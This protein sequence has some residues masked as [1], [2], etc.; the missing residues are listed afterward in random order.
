MSEKYDG[1][2]EQY[3]HFKNTATLP[4]PER[5]TFLKL[6][7]DLRGLRVMDLACGTGVYTRLLKHQGATRMVGVDI[8][9][10]MV[11]QALQQEREAPLG[12]EFVVEDALKMKP[13]HAFD[14]VTA[15]YLLNYA[16]T[17]EELRG[18]FRCAAGQLEGDGRFVSVTTHPDFSLSKPNWTK[19]GLSVR[20]LVDEGERVLC[21]TEFHVQPPLHMSCFNWKKHVYEWAAREAG[22]QRLTWHELEIPPEELRTRGAEY[23]RDYQENPLLLALVCHKA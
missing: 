5:Y 6:A 10:D 4:L 17:R 12:I 9:P 20:E 3:A 19:Y 18:M 16:S 7:G 1:A 22:F 13:T 11:Q 21:S 23:W 15:V 8:S 14:L 2:G